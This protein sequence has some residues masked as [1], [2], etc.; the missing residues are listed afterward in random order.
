MLIGKVHRA[1]AKRCC[2]PTPSKSYSSRQADEAFG[3]IACQVSLI[4]EYLRLLLLSLFICN[5]MLTVEIIY[6]EVIEI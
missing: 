1:G 5:D 4:L 3:A 6:P 2:S